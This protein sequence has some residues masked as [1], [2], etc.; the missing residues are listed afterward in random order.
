MILF[1][2]FDYPNFFRIVVTVPEKLMVEAC[3][4]IRLFCQQHYLPHR[5]DS[6]EL[7]Q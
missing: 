3:G 2:A 1:Q 7:D 6:S 4:R 5:A